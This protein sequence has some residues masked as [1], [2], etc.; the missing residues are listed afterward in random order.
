MKAEQE[1]QIISNGDGSRGRKRLSKEQIRE[2]EKRK[3]RRRR[4]A[5]LARMVAALF[6]ILMVLVCVLG[7][8]FIVSFFTDKEQTGIL[9]EVQAQIEE[10]KVNHM[11]KPTIVQDFL[12]VNE[13]SRPG[14]E[15]KKV[16]KIFIHYTA[17]P[18]TSAS[19]NRSYFESLAE[20][21]ECSASA[22]F[23]IGYEGE[24]VQCLPLTEIGYAVVGR[25]EDSISIECCYQDESGV[26]TEATLNSLNQLT[27]WLLEE[28]D[29]DDSDVLRH[30]DEGGKLC[31]KYYVE[32]ETEWKE[33]VYNIGQYRK[34]KLAEVQDTE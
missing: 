10:K 25:N 13:F 19:Q 33:V 4:K 29:L 11:P 23:V 22:H 5:I 31:P 9:A 1:V 34:E 7:I 28:Y 14:T 26:F 32:H 30:Y 20:T 2:R 24:I 18:G 27:A 16:K 15:L 21:G 12:S 17:N 8:R 6:L 3:K